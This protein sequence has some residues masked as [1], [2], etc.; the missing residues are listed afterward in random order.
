MSDRLWGQSICNAASTLI[1]ALLLAEEL[2]QIFDKADDH[3]YRGSSHPNQED[4]AQQ[5]HQ[6]IDNR[7]IHRTDSTTAG[8]A[9][10]L[11]AA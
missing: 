10:P 3:H 8:V 4:K 2:I 7:M 5:L 6:E 1:L 11:P 9:K